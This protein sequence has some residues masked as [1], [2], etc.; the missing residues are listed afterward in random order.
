MDHGI[1]SKQSY[2]SKCSILF[3]G[4]SSMLPG[5]MVQYINN[6]E[7]TIDLSA[8]AAEESSDYGSADSGAADSDSVE[9]VPEAS[10]FI[11]G[12]VESMED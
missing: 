4:H 7:C 11:D 12:L 8:V 2:T 10:D 5:Y 3:Q 1:K 6:K 9:S